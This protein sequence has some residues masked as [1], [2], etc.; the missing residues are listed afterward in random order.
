MAVPKRR[1]S[2][3]RTRRRRSHHR[4]RPVHLVECPSCHEMR[5]P[6]RACPNCGNY[7]GLLVLDVESAS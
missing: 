5:L 4:L 7:R 2:K 1:Q 6:H 3:G